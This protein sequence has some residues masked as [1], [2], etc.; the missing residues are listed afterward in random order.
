MA[1]TLRAVI[2][3][4]QFLIAVAVLSTACTASEASEPPTQATG[5]TSSTTATAAPTTTA[6][7]TTTTTTRPI[8]PS[9]DRI[10][11]HH[12][13]DV[14][15]DTSFT[16]HFPDGFDVAFSGL[17]EIFLHDELTIVN[18]ECAPT[19]IRT[20]MSAKEWSFRCD[21]ESLAAMARNGVDVA[22]MAN[23]HSGDYGFD[24]L[25]D[26]RRRLQA[27]GLNPVG[28]GRDLTEAN[29]PVIFEIGGWT[30]GV[31]AFSAVSGFSYTW[32]KP[33]TYDLD[34]QWFAS[35]GAPGVAPAR[36]DNMVDVVTALDDA[37]DVVIVSLHQEP[38]NETGIPE[39]IERERAQAV[40]EAGADVVVAH[41]H[42]RLMAFE[43]LEGVPIFWGMGNFVWSQMDAIRNTTAVAEIV[44]GTDG[45]ITGRLV[46]AYIESSGRPVLRGTP[47]FAV[48]SDRLQ[49]G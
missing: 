29:E 31:V 17:D 27:A 48:R 34:N 41:H 14:N 16:W 35:E 21:P 45:T 40:I 7:P 33:W 5:T 11:I 47:D 6:G 37:V 49:L 38:Y 39:P 36:L 30:V 9:R 20:R 43:Y 46:P 3:A 28:A 25:I 26:G 22:V 8:A 19:D 15:F 24:G 2:R 32:E 1:S 13:G 10:V 23:N 44:I 12:V 42:H 4:R 18:L